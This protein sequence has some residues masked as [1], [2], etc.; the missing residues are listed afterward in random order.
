MSEEPKPRRR[1]PVLQANPP[2]AEEEEDRPAPSW[3]LIG[4]F[5]M[6]LA[7]TFTAGVV[8]AVLQRIV[9]EAFAVVIIG[10]LLAFAIAVLVGAFLLGARA[11][12]V[13]AKRTQLVGSLVAVLGVMYG[14]IATQVAFGIAWILAAV[15]LVI[16]ANVSAR[17]GWKLGRR[18]RA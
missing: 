11:K 6:L 7:W 2:D 9:S 15:I 16:V 14:F 5:A 18:R 17:V 1:L 3:M 10:N 4:G 8:N 13:D 12:S